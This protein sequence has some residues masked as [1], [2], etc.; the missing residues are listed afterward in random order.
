MSTSRPLAAL[1]LVALSAGCVQEPPANG[2]EGDGALRLD[3]RGPVR[4]DDGLGGYE[5]SLAVAPDGTLIMTAHK[6][7]LAN[8]GTR[9]SS[10]LWYSQDGGATWREIE[11]PAALHAKLPGFE[12]DVAVDEAGRLYFVDTVIG[13]N[14]L[15]RWKLTGGTPQWESSRPLQG[16]AG[17]D[18]RP[19][20][21]AQGD[22]IV[23]YVGNNGLLPPLSTTLPRMSLSV[24]EDRGTVFTVRALFEGSR[25]CVPD[26]APADDVSVLVVCEM[27]DDTI[28]AHASDDRGVTWDVREVARCE[29]LCGAGYASAA[30]D[31]A[32][33]GYVSWLD[34]R[35]S[36]GE[37][38]RVMLGVQEED[39]WRVIDVTPRSAFY[40]MA[41]VASYVPGTVAIGYYAAELG[42]EPDA[43]EWWPYVLVGDARATGDRVW[44]EVRVDAEPVKIAVGPPGDFLQLAAGR[45]GCFHLGYQRDLAQGTTG[46]IAQVHHAA[47]CLPADT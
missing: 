26:A 37:P 3:V 18:D 7:N 45:A 25:W 32:G 5:P 8:E 16:T 13:D 41:W 43:R 40:G 42:T 31:A 47:V 2:S 38:T 35:I 4:V 20:L 12:G 39:R 28:Q 1:V 10:W 11:S 44:R 30:I 34:G 6:N 17:G 22:G 15:S 19:W 29:A 46:Q 27:E 24:S 14:T 9:L 23:Y 33:V 21:A 36:S